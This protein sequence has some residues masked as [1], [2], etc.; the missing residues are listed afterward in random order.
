MA[1]SGYT[2]WE[3][4]AG[5]GS[6]TAGGGFDPSQTAGMNTDGAATSATG[7]SPVFTSASY[8]FGSGDVGARLFIASGTNWIPG[9]YKIASVAANAATLNATAGQGV[10][11]GNNTTNGLT[12]ATGCATTASPT[13]ATWSID[14]SQ[15]AAAQVSF[16]DLVIGATTTNL[17]S[18]GNPFGKQWVGN[19]LNVTS[20]T[21]FTTGWY[22]IKSVATV[23]ATMDRSVGTAAATGGHG[24]M[25][26]AWATLTNI[27]GG[28][29]I[30]VSGNLC[31]FTGSL[32]ITSTYTFSFSAGNASRVTLWGYSTYRGD[33]GQ[34]TV[35]CATN[36]VAAFTLAGPTSL[37]FRSL[38]LHCT[39]GTQG[40]GI[41]ASSQSVQITVQDCTINGWNIGI[42]DGG[43]QIWGLFVIE[44]LIENSVSHGVQNGGST[45]L[46]GCY[47]YKNGGDGAQSYGNNSSQFHAYCTVA[48]QNTLA[49][50]HQAASSTISCFDVL[51]CV[52]YDNTTDGL[53]IDSGAEQ[54]F[55]VINTIFEA[56]GGYG[57]NQKLP[58]AASGFAQGAASIQR[59][60]A[61]YNNTSGAR[62]AN[63][64]AGTGDVIYTTGAFVS[65]S[66]G[67]FTLNS[68]TGG[69]AL[70][71]L[72]GWQS[73]L[74]N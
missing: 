2:I 3:V 13:G 31:W 21:N 37:E 42:Y 46:F 26:G 60:N 30:W 5:S 9:W 65:A 36:S 55:N 32:T 72:A 4:E 47:L 22:V 38:I 18:V 58:P 7:A 44:C 63:S 11:Y 39:A 52:A 19:L 56:N 6:D 10:L 41:T 34:A 51:D 12:T 53:E 17:T 64:A 71:Q 73:N 1:L 61:F 8:N 28:S 20:G 40:N 57:I 50:F 68:T 54:S 14:Y 69:G 23:T 49:G 33:G 45:Q 43:H 66:T 29:P 48:S 62:L 70:L 27:S 15:Q 67:N 25:G 16:T 35:T 59:N 24:N 74:T